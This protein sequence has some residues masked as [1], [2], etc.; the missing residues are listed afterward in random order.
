MSAVRPPRWPAVA[1]TAALLLIALLPWWRNHDHLRDLYDYGLVIAANGRLE[2]GEKPYVDF[3]TPIQA[4][5]LGMNWLA[6]KT[7]GGTYLGMTRAAAALIVLS[8]AGLTLMLSRRWPVWAAGLVALA[9]TVA[10]PAQHTILWHNALGLV[11]LALVVWSAAIAPV[12]RR[13]TWP[14][15][16]ILFA[17][18]L[19]GGLNKLNFQLVA[20]AAAVAWA[21]RAGLAARAGWGRVVAT[22][23]AVAT[24]GFA[25]PLVV[26]LAWTGAS[27]EV[28]WRNVVQL[29]FTSRSG[30]L[31]KIL[32][33]GFLL[34]PIH[35]YYGP[36]FIPQVGLAGQVMSAL[37]LPACWPGK[38]GLRLDRFLLP[39]AVVAI[40]LAGAALLATNQEIAYLGLGAWLVLAVSVW[41]GFAPTLRPGWLTAGIVLPALL[42]GAA[43]W[44]SAWQGQRSQF[45]Y[46]ESPRSAYRDAREAGPNFARLGA[47]KLPPE[48]VESLTTLERWLPASDAHGVRPVFY[49]A[50]TEWLARFLPG[51]T[52]KN[53]PLWIHWGTTYG[54]RETMRLMQTLVGDRRYQV[55]LTSLAR[56]SWPEE[57]RHNL[58]QHFDRSLIGPVTVR[59][60]RHGDTAGA[61]GDSLEF[62]NRCGGNVAGA[63]LHLADYPLTLLPAGEAG[64]VMGVKGGQ[65]SMQLATPTY[66]FGGD[67]VLVRTA[68]A[69][70]VRAD[71][72]VVVHGAVPEEVRWAATIDLP[73]G[74][75]AVTV[76]FKLDTLGRSMLLQITVPDE[77]FGQV[78]AGYR[79][80][81]ITH[82]IETEGGAP[83]LRA[84]AAAEQDLLA[85]ASGPLWGEVTWRARHAV[86]RGGRMSDA[87]VVLPA[88]GELWL[89]TPG[90]SGEL[91][92]RIT[93]PTAGARPLVRVVWCKG[94]RLQIMQQ[95]HVPENG[96]FDFHV[97]TAEPGGWIGVVVDPGQDTAPAVVRL[98]S[99]S[100]AP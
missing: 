67:A 85:E 76:P 47:V 14:W 92:G 95:G 50:G 1:F 4:G 9:V 10:G 13:E 79:N 49:A 19:L 71:F 73:A 88:A 72:K 68:G 70:A 43:S 62:I 65:G 64:L 16:G 90:M 24:A 33:T 91:R 34:K 59:W 26:E 8:G 38:D 75:T 2:A 60:V 42:L 37:L 5:F 93:A 78:V 100:F 45:G 32:S 25:L 36:L 20:V 46:S 30:D 3:L 61:L 87:G 15:H 39:L 82:A 96:A 21:L 41:L 6:E 77:F 28:W 81:Q 40:T 99:A 18:L 27:F 54:P 83:R 80:L 7:G 51:R 12:L 35:D 23:V 94:G 66:R 56:D 53:L 44:A 11:A 69:G 86:T 97:W 22:L 31:E 58:G 29:A 89:H 52:E 84:G 74:E 55:I 57:F 98:L 17:G 63:A 48:M